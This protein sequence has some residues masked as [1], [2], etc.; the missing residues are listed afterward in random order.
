MSLLCNETWPPRGQGGM[1]SSPQPWTLRP[2]M[3]MQPSLESLKD[4]RNAT[5][6]YPQSE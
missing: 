1:G 3:K 2:K 5:R 6:R 4:K